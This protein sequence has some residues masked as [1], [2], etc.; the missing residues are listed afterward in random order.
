MDKVVLSGKKVKGE[1]IHTSMMRAWERAV[2]AAWAAG[3][4]DRLE[5]L[6]QIAEMQGDAE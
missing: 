2:D 6:L 5:Q 3:D 4:R 1:S